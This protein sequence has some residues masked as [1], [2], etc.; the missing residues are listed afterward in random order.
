MTH[1]LSVESTRPSSSDK[2]PSPA[3][4]SGLSSKRMT[5]PVLSETSTTDGILA[6]T[7][8]LDMLN[9]DSRRN[10]AYCLAVEKTIT[11]TC[12]VLDI[13]FSFS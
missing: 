5:K 13:G 3:N 2:T 10:R 4:R 7:S 6:T 11:E 8:Y 9:D 12:H 1:E